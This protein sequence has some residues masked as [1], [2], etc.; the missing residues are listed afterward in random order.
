MT[1]YKKISHSATLPMTRREERFLPLVEM[2]GIS[3]KNG[4]CGATAKPPHHTPFFPRI[5]GSFRTQRSEVRNLVIITSDGK[6]MLFSSLTDVISLVF[7]RSAKSGTNS[8]TPISDW[9]IGG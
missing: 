2:T 3:Q 5:V 6:F 8:N 9:R 1:G 4:V 7:N